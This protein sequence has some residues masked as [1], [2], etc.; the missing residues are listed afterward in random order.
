[1]TNLTRS[2]FQ[3]HPF[4]LVSPSPWP[5][6]ISTTLFT[7]T[8][9]AVLTFH[10]FSNA[11]SIL[12]IGL[13]C[14]I[15]SMCLWFKDVTNEGT[16]LGNHTLALVCLIG[17][18]ILIIFLFLFG[19][20]LTQSFVQSRNINASTSVVG[21]GSSSGFSGGG[22][23]NAG[24]GTN[25]TAL[26]AGDIDN[27]EC[28]CENHPNI[29]APEAEGGLPHCG[30]EHTNTLISA[31][32]LRACCNETEAPSSHPMCEERGYITCSDCGCSFCSDTCKNISARGQ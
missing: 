1:M 26:T 19:D 17:L 25:A 8:L 21:G 23:N 32:P 14:V 20:D 28:P 9:G 10:S 31:S 5:L 22:P 2:N 24:G 4:H 13:I 30:C 29:N 12:N 7:S 6:Y 16:Y 27:R 18:L 11:L 3:A 15:Y